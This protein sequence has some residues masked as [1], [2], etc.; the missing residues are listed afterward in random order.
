M[1]SRLMVEDEQRGILRRK[2]LILGEI[3]DGPPSARD[4]ETDNISTTAR[5]PSV[6]AK[7]S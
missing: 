5:L 2:Q 1:F 7:H 6:H 4:G 3:L